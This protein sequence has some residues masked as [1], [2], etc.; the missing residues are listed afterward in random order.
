M[1]IEYKKKTIMVNHGQFEVG[2]YGKYT[3]RAEILHQCDS[4]IYGNT[5]EEVVEKI[6]QYI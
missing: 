5:E 3:Y 6:K 1:T 4:Y 2:T